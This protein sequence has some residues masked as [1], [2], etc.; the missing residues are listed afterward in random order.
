ME[1][2]AK[3]TT[4]VSITDRLL[5]TDIA[6]YITEHCCTNKSRLSIPALSR[7][8]GISPTRIK[9]VFKK[10]HQ[11]SIHQYLLHKRM[12]IASTLLMETDAVVV[13]IKCG[14]NDYCNFCRDFKRIVGCKPTEYRCNF[15]LNQ[16]A[17]NANLLNLNSF[18]YSKILYQ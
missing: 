17:Q 1:S 7:H 6:D 16:S 2:L 14:Y 4:V 13:A 3:Q 9:I 5:A 10:Y 15:R 11:Q 12:Q 18:N 8:F